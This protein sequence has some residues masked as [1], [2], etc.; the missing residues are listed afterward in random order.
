MTSDEAA[1]T[2]D[3]SCPDRRTGAEVEVGARLLI[4]D[5]ARSRE[6]EGAKTDGGR[7]TDLSIGG[8]HR[9]VGSADDG[10][11]ALLG[12]IATDDVDRVTA[13]VSLRK[14]LGSHG[15]RLRV[16]SEA[17]KL[18]LTAVALHLLR[19][20]ASMTLMLLRWHRLTAGHG[21][22]VEQGFLLD[23]KLFEL[24][25]NGELLRH[26]V[27]RRHLRRSHVARRRSLLE[28]GRL[29]S[30]ERRARDLLGGWRLGEL[31]L[32]LGEQVVL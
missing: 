1:S 24:S 21:E 4:L 2:A 32:H 23:A 20:H 17:G 10:C 6:L 26:E 18:R 15:H 30:V 11:A 8:R 14:G 25:L 16:A 3:A 19:L 28:A 5:A 9:R 29:R 31:R 13:P 27:R 22:S 7:G 12:R